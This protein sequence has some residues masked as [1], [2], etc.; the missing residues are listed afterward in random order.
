MYLFNSFLTIGDLECLSKWKY[1]V[2]DNGIMSAAFN[3]FYNY[4]AKMIPR[5]VSPNALSFSGL[6][7]SLIAWYISTFTVS[8]SYNLNNIMIGI[9]IALYTILDA[10]DGKHAR[11]TNTSSSLGELVDHFCDCITNVMLTITLCN[12]Y[13]IEGDE[14]R[15]A[16]VFF[17][18]LIFLKQH[19]D[20]LLG[21]H[22]IVFG[23]FTGPTE[24]LCAIILL[25]WFEPFLIN[26]NTGK[27]IEYVICGYALYEFYNFINVFIKYYRASKDFATIFGFGVCLFAQLI[28]LSI[29]KMSSGYFGSYIENGIIIS[30][31]CGDIILAKMANRELHQLVPIMHLITCINYNFS[32]PLAVIYFVINIWDISNYTNVSILNPTVNVFVCGYYDGFHAGHE[33]SLRKAS[34]LGTNLFVGIHSQEE[35]VLKTK[36]KNQDPITKNEVIRYDAVKKCKF[37]T[38][39]LEGCSPYELSEEFIKQNKIHVV[40]A[41]DEYVKSKTNDFYKT[42]ERITDNLNDYNMSSDE[43]L[44]YVHSYYLDAY[45]L[46]ILQIIPRTNGISSTE[47]RVANVK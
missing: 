26:F 34:K 2:E 7:M 10:L 19:F 38:K 22:K 32:I 25:I 47:L 17:V 39:V 5:N 42:E 27:I 11:N 35:L 40:G 4:L 8:F 24:A 46:K 29:S 1:K 12:V 21:D 18:Q 44:V 33:E 37:V 41:S 15:W 45:K 14:R 36:Q 3:P 16:I 13:N 28:K 20:A 30:T 9:F 6:I 23:R 43:N 31:L